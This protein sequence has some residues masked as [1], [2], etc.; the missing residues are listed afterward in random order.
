MTPHPVVSWPGARSAVGE[1]L[2]ASVK[3]SPVSLS[4]EW[5][6]DVRFA[7]RKE[8]VHLGM[9]SRIRTQSEITNPD[10]WSRSSPLPGTTIV[11]EFNRELGG[12]DVNKAN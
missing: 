12:T 5:V 2:S 6:T 7:E 1:L 3:N 4:A 9:T 11:G 10:R 8:P